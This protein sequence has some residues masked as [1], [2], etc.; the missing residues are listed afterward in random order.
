MNKLF[1]FG[2]GAATG[3][4]LT[5]KLIEKKYKDLADEEIASV[6]ERFEVRN[7]HVKPEI[8]FVVEDKNEIDDNV[9]TVKTPYK[10]TL[11]DLGYDLDENDTIISE[12]KDGSIFMEPC[13]DY[14]KPYVISP[15]EFGEKEYY[16]ARYWTYY[17]DFVMTNET[18]EIVVDPEEYIGDALLHFGEYED[19][20][21]HV[22]NENVES[23]YEITRIEE[24]FT[25]INKNIISPSGDN[26]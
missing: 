15:D 25:E 16:N 18:G 21:V 4:L 23:D 7:E 12:D 22:R 20:T 5:W 9:K 13:V 8:E 3:S 14:V 19:D 2:L 11:Q 24:S 17:S 6:V 1:I 26:V 10:R